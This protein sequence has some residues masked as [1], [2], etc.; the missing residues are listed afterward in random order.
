MEPGTAGNAVQLI[1]F[2]GICIGYI[3]TYIF[4][5][6]NKA[7]LLLKK[8]PRRSPTFNDADCNTCRCT[9]SYITYMHCLP[10][11]M[12]YVKQL[13]D[14]EEAVMAKRLAEMPPEELE[15]LLTEVRLLIA[16]KSKPRSETLESSQHAYTAKSACGGDAA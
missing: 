6:A 1:V 15:R 13:E 11:D 3:S 7:R 12:T 5:V 2:F 16:L 9:V 4:R 8:L 14:Y 10:Q